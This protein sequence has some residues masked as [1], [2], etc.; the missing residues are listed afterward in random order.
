MGKVVV[1]GDSHTYGNGLKDARLEKPWEQH[2]YS[3]WP[4]YVFD[5][6]DIE[7]VSYPGCSNDMIF[8]RLLR[9][10]KA[11]NKVAILFSYPERLHITKKG[12]NFNFN[13]NFIYPVS[14]SGDENWVADQ[15]VRKAEVKNKEFLLNHYDDDFLEI[16]FYKNILICQNFCEANNIDYYFSMVQVREKRKMSGSLEIY[17]DNLI[18]SINWN[19]VFLVEQKYGFTDYAKVINAERGQDD[20]HWNEQYHK[21]FGKLFLDWINK[22]KV[23]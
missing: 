16:N 13:Y 19:Y 21:T 10:A 12:Y 5:K 23:L 11:D 8:L 18:N 17:R 2:S 3:S 20:I 6:Q 4:Y 22:E 15:I 7:N 1:L 9:Y 14:D